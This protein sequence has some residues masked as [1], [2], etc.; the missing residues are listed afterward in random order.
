MA[1]GSENIFMEEEGFYVSQTR[2]TVSVHQPGAFS[3][4]GMTGE[5]R[6]F[7]TRD[8]SS[9]Q[10]ASDNAGC[11]RLLGIALLVLVVVIAIAA[12]VALGSGEILSGLV[13]L[14]F[15]AGA[16]GL[17]IARRQW[18]FARTYYATLET[19]RDTGNVQSVRTKERELV[20]RFANAVAE[21]VS[22]RDYDRPHGG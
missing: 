1:Q 2:V 14:V 4:Q 15:C 18:F 6:T 3:W 7:L 8:I 5:Q 13:A 12:L 21:A 20:Q 10:V 9:V 17:A 16:G 19:Y 22:A 11:A